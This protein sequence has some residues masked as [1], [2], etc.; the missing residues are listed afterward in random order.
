MADPR[1]PPDDEPAFED[2]ALTAALDAILSDT[3]VDW[4]ASAAA[5]SDPAL[6]HELRVLAGIAAMHRALEQGDAEWGHLQIRE[7][8]GEGAFGEVFRAW[9]PRLDREVALK[10]FA[11]RSPLTPRD[12]RAWVL[13]EARHLAAIRHPNVVTV[14]GADRIDGRVGFWTEF[15]K[16]Q[17][18]AQLIESRGPLAEGEA[19]AIC[20]DVC[21]ALSAVHGAGLLHRDIK[22]NNVM[23]EEG[24]RIVLLDFG[25]T[26][27]VVAETRPAAVVGDPH[28]PTGTPLYVAPELWLQQ[29]ATPQSDVYS[30]GVLLY[31]LVTGTY[32][33]QGATVQDVANAHRD[34]ARTPVAAVKP[35]LSTAFVDLVDRAIAPDPASRFADVDALQL[36]LDRAQHRP[37]ASIGRWLWR[38]AGIAAVIALLAAGGLFWWQRPKSIAAL[39]IVSAPKESGQRYQG[40]PSHDGRFFAYIDTLRRVRVWEIA[41]QDDQVITPQ[42]SPDS[43]AT[44]ALS[45]RLG[46]ALPTCG[47]IQTK[48]SRSSWRSARTRHY[49]GVSWHVDPGPYLSSKTGPVMGRRSLVGCDRWVALTPISCSSHRPTAPQSGYSHESC[50]ARKFSKRLTRPCR[51]INVSSLRPAELVPRPT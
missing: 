35:G 39:S 10:L 16:G 43:F 21:R 37:A 48:R 28:G 41:R 23:R 3:P 34:G 25:A 33:V 46:I 49:D 18:L 47:V 42:S 29:P 44:S 14:Y 36:A 31:F 27:N 32:P 4:S 11:P 19:I 12:D 26:K 2:P 45:R 8:V 9:D 51:Q 15:I 24:G 17:T 50:Q 13:E 6:A 5:G 40:P 1:D 20:V 7:K 22:A 38:A 30:L